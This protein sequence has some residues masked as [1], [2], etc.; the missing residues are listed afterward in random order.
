[1][2]VLVAGIGNVLRADDG[3]G[4]AVV[5]EL[6]RAGGLPHGTRTLEVGIGGISLVHE[7]LS[8]YD[9][10]ILLDAIDRGGP[11]GTLYV[12]EPEVPAADA[13]PAA[14]RALAAT[15]MHEVVPSRVLLMARSLG[16][17]PPV[18]RIVGCQPQETE[19]LSTELTAVVAGMLPRA[20]DMVR[21]IVAELMAMD[22]SAA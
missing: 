14:E 11:P 9:A 15:D 12:L 4:P 6:D 8:S 5:Q 21:G 7:L 2:R 20:V 17:L 16:V 10:L 22:S 19:V 3:F 1:M 18:V 13:I